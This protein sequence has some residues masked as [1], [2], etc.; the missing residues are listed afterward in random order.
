MAWYSLIPVD[1]EYH[2]IEAILIKCFIAFG[3]LIGGPGW[4][5]VVYDFIVYCYRI[6]V[7]ELLPRVSAKKVKESQ[8]SLLYTG[9]GEVFE[10]RVG[11]E[12]DGDITT[13]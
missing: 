5:L 13:T 10:E 3:V 1:S 11:V 12:D 4:S 7:Y 2:Y 9:S 8:V 6:V